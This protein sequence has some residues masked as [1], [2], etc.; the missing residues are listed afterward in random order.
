MTSD[1]IYLADKLVEEWI[2]EKFDSEDLKDKTG[3]SKELREFLEKP[4]EK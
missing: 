3:W 2:E 4:S 1:E